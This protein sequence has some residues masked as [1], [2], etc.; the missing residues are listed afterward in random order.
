MTQEIRGVWIVDHTHSPVLTSPS[1]I[2]KALDF[3]EANGFNLV[4]PA[5]WNRGLTAFPSQVMA[6]QGFPAQDPFYGNAGFDPLKEIV[7][8]GKQRGMA[9]FPWFE[10]GFAASAQPNGGHILQTKRLPRNN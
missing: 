8:Q 7:S 2:A 9:I 10:Y 6:S 4:C 1:N 3:L 5:V